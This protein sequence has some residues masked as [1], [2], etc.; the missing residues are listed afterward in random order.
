MFALYQSGGPLLGVGDTV[1]QCL[2]EARAYLT[3]KP[4]LLDD[5]GMPLDVAM[6]ED[7]TTIPTTTLEIDG[8]LYVRRTSQAVA[9]AMQAPG[10]HGEVRYTIAP[11]GR[12]QLQEVS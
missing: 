8:E 11:D 9:D 6:Y 5:D 4:F 2:E 3:D 1:D 10:L 7:R 12:V